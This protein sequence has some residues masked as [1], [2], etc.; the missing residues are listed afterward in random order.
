MSLPHTFYCFEPLRQAE[1]RI[2]L[3]YA[4][5]QAPPYLATNLG[6]RHAESMLAGSPRSLYE[7]PQGLLHAAGYS[8]QAQEA[9]APTML[10][11]GDRIQQS[12]VYTWPYRPRSDLLHL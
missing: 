6:H 1:L 10:T 8:K 3:I 9:P 11:K 12:Q 5:A 4:L 7:A 2:W